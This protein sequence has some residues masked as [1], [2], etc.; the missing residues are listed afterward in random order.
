MGPETADRIIAYGYNAAG[1]PDHLLCYRP[2]TGMVSIIEEKSE[3]PGS[4][5]FSKVFDSTS[6]I[7][8][9]DLASPAD[10]IIAYDYEGAGK[11]EHLVCYRPGGTTICIIAETVTVPRLPRR[12]CAVT[13]AAR[14]CPALISRALI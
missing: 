7:G 8:G 10:Q 1:H 12:S 13:W 11:P 14:T 6:G 5:T 4:V 2:G 9:Y 3:T